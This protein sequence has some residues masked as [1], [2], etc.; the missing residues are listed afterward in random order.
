MRLRCVDLFH[1]RIPLKAPF[2]TSFGVT[3]ERETLLLR[4]ESTDGAVGWGEW[5]GDGPG[6]SY[7]TIQ[8]AWHIL[9]DY[10]IPLALRAPFERPQEVVARFAPVRGHNITKATLEAALWDLFAQQA[11][12]SLREYIAQQTGHATRDRVPVGVSIGIQPT[13]EQLVQRV[14]AFLAEGYQRI[15]IKIKPG[16]DLADARAVREAFPEVPLMVDANSAYT[17]NDA[18]LFQQMDTL[19][20]MMIEQPLGYDDIYEHSRLQPLLQTPICLDESIHSLGHAQLALAVGACRVINIKQGRCGGLTQAIAIHDFCMAA[21]VPVW[22]GGMLETGVG[23]ALNVA[24]ASL[25]NFT[26]PGDLSASNRYYHEDVIDPPFVLNADGTLDV[27]RG[28][29]LG[30]RVREA[31]VRALT[32]RQARFER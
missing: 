30:V 4:A 26:L 16:R 6:Y 32:M 14:G 11:G 9:S 20:L 21:G 27:P 8:T 17:L 19:G 10:L 23:R 15:K 13:P 24:L 7:E 22:C 29:G 31:R 2:E 18:P 28:I 1:I 12:L 25:P 3:A 5:A